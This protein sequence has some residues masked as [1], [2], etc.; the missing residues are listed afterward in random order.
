MKIRF[1]ALLAALTIFGV[2]HAAAQ[3][4]RKQLPMVHM[5][6]LLG[7]VETIPLPTDGWMDHLAVDLKNHH[8][9]ISGENSQNMVVVDLQTSKVIHVTSGL[10]G[11][12]RKPFFD[13]KTNQV[14]VDLGDNTLVAIDATSFEV[15]RTVELTGGKGAAKRDPDNGAYDYA[16]GLYYSGAGTAGS[17]DGTVEIVDTRAARLVGSIPMH[18]SDPSAFVLDA[19]GKR[20]YVG[21]GDVVN[22]ESVC[23]VIDTEKREV[24]AEWPIT[25]G[26]QP[27][28][29]GL[30]LPH[31][32]LF[33]GS[34]LQGG[35]QG[36]PGKL[37][38][39]DSNTGKV[40]QVLDSVGGADELMFDA[41]TKR[42]YFSGSTGTV[43]V[44]KQDD[45]D[46][47]ELL[48]KV[49]T[50][51]EAKT[52]LWVPELKRYYAAVPKH[53]VQTP[54]YGANDLITE[55]AHLMVFDYLP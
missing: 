42:I 54:P 26:A 17:P 34:R 28:V 12:P 22:G 11:K 30:D 27:H 32:R 40:I 38:V 21:M 14:W 43:A 47:Y 20:L 4:K 46:H 9:F 55:D 45:A 37:V 33:F 24:I 53:I 41:P 3:E 7:L 50:G 36:E 29:A 10:G 48:G 51:A 49:P 1:A 2:W 8:L 25:G 15:V 16:S 52:G 35:H 19:A 13:P 18:G 31:H 6:G 44:F 23:K 5:R 39:M